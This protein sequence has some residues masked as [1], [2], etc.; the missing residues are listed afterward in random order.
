[1]ASA[2]RGS[3]AR[4]GFRWGQVGAFVPVSCMHYNSD[5][6]KTPARPNTVWGFRV[7]RRRG[8]P[9]GWHPSPEHK[10]LTLLAWEGPWTHVLVQMFVL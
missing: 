1:M 6:K 4:T 7:T 10:P 8:S 9:L 5:V 3:P 2:A